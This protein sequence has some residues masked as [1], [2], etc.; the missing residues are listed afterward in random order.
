MSRNHIY[1]REA[2]GTVQVAIGEA[3][4]RFSV[5]GA[6]SC[7]HPLPKR[8]EVWLVE[9]WRQ[10]R[11][12]A[13]VQESA[14]VSRWPM[15]SDSFRRCTIAAAP[16]AGAI[17][18][19]RRCVGAIENAVAAA[20]VAVAVDA[21]TMIVVATAA[22]VGFCGSYE[23]IHRRLRVTVRVPARSF[24]T[25]SLGMGQKEMRCAVPVQCR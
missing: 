4:D 10:A 19:S 21:V 20:V 11:V 3:K 5:A 12:S 15:G 1:P 6:S 18:G 25:A 23:V 13:A 14:V 8:C 7:P 16:T 22:L 17:S 9:R 2:V 24:V